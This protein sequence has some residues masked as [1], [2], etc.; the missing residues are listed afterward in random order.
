MKRPRAGER[1]FGLRDDSGARQPLDLK[2]WKRSA[3]ARD[4]IIRE[5]MRQARRA[6]RCP[7]IVAIAIVTAGLVALLW[8][9]VMRSGFTL[10][11][12]VVLTVFTTLLTI[13]LRM[14]LNPI[15]RWMRARRVVP[16]MKTYRLCAACAYSLDE[17]AKT[18]QLTACPECGARWDLDANVSYDSAGLARTDSIAVFLAIFR[19]RV[20]MFQDDHGDWHRWNPTIL[21]RSDSGPDRARVHALRREHGR[22]VVGAILG[23][24]V[25]LIASAGGAR[26]VSALLVRG[27]TYPQWWVFVVVSGGFS[28]GYFHILG[29]ALR[30]SFRGVRRRLVVRGVSPCCGD[31]LEAESDESGWQ[32]CPSCSSRWR[33]DG[34]ERD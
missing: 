30:R 24:V 9:P 7:W 2:Q 5:S 6:I 15:A 32:R 31:G 33:L 1:G 27:G 26:A 19:P 29:W 14:A 11:S 18:G 3:A 23:L 28:L 34:S 4:P 17:I 20:L 22:I 21:L 10:V 13:S 12:V 8:N 25:A 16:F